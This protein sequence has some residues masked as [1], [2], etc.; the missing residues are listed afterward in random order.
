MRMDVLKPDKLHE[1]TATFNALCERD[2]TA[3][4]ILL[5]QSPD[6]Q[7][8][9]SPSNKFMQL[10]IDSA[11]LAL[12]NA[13][14]ISS[15]KLSIRFKVFVLEKLSAE[16]RIAHLIEMADIEGLT[17]TLAPEILAILTPEDWLILRGKIEISALNDDRR[18][19]PEKVFKLLRYFYLN[20]MDQLLSAI[21]EQP[22]LSSSLKAQ[23]LLFIKTHSH[24]AFPDE[25][26]LALSKQDWQALISFIGEVTPDDRLKEVFDYFYN[27]CPLIL[28][29][30]LAAHVLHPSLKAKALF[31]AASK[32]V[33]RAPSS[34]MAP[35]WKAHYLSEDDRAELRVLLTKGWSGMPA[36][37]LLRSFLSLPDPKEPEPPSKLTLYISDLKNSF[38]DFIAEQF[39]D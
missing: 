8:I 38:N 22:H 9:D 21:K 19:D 6:Y 31:Y 16:S 33:A 18:V 39:A 7:T 26:R 20:S 27:E 25:I 1:V 23:Y 32:I 35:S 13:L 3:L 10:L 24:R 11:P 28:M 4:C 17:S 34:R 15:K 2:F 14:L 36:D 37:D 5:D 12:S 30:S 29:E